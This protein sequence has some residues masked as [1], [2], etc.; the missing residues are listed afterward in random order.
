MIGS[1]NIGFCGAFV[2]A[3]LVPSFGQ[4]RSDGEGLFGCGAGGGAAQGPGGRGRRLDPGMLRS[5][6]YGVL[7]TSHEGQPFVN[8]NLFVYAEDE[9]AIYMHTARTGRTA[10]NVGAEERVAFTVFEMGRLLP[11]PRAFN[12]SVEY[13]GVVVFGRAQV[14]DVGG[15]EAARAG[16]AGREVL[17]APDAGSGLCAAVG[18]GAGTDVGVPDRD[19]FLVGEAE[20]C[21][22]GLRWCVSVG[23]WVNR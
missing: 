14:L 23:R 4:R 18:G 12:M 3:T 15:G 16:A 19:R 6:A 11:A 20:D 10:S 1:A 21:G 13:E 8:S 2:H 5:A 17:L 7:A 22:C 9:H